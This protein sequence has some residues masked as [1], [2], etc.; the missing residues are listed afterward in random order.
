MTAD[1]NCGDFDSVIAVIVL[2]NKSL[3][4]GESYESPGID[5]F[6]DWFFRLGENRIRPK[7]KH[8]SNAVRQSFS[9]HSPKECVSIMNCIARAI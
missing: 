7:S 5:R 3:L 6:L 8:I 2:K 1:V 4:V 9:V